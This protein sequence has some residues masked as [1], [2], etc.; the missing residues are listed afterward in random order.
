MAP[1][2]T[3]HGS[4]EA[5]PSG[6][7]PSED[8]P[9]GAEPSEDQPSGGQDPEAG[10]APLISTLAL[11]VFSFFLAALLG[12]SF[13]ASALV[14]LAQWL[15]VGAI[16]PEAVERIF[17]G[18]DDVDPVLGLWLRAGTLPLTLWIAWFF[19]VKLD[20]AGLSALGLRRPRA[21]GTEALLGSFAAALTLMVW[22]L[23]IAPMVSSTSPRR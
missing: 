23:G 2:P 13:G 20:S 15:D 14:S 11:R 3:A 21:A 8:R 22:F 16:D 6:S 18:E 10:P 5:E 9:S 19:I 7:E 12:I 4:S 17:Q 1:E